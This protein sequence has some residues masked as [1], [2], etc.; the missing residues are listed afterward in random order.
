LARKF[1][2]EGLDHEDWHLVRAKIKRNNRSEQE[3]AAPFATPVRQP[4]T[5][6]DVFAPPRNPIAST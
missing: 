5:I 6:G 4:P 1:F 3:D 2:L